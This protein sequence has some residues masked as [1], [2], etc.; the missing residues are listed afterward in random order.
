MFRWRSI[1]PRPSKFTD[2]SA[3][4]SALSGS[5]SSASNVMNLFFAHAPASYGQ[6]NP[7]RLSIVRLKR[8]EAC[9]LA[10]DFQSV[11]EAKFT[12][13]RKRPYRYVSLVVLRESA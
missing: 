8:K 9:H 3:F 2:A 11:V 1:P 4:R 5:A 12:G 13:T 6:A 7:R 10:A